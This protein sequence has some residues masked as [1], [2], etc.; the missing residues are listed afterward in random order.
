VSLLVVA[1][2]TEPAM[3]VAFLIGGGLGFG[4]F[5]SNH[6]AATQTLAGPLASGRWTG[7]ENFTG[8]L[9]GPVAPV[10]VG[11]VVDRTGQY[12]AAFAVAAAITLVG[13][14]AWTFVIRDVREVR[15]RS[16]PESPVLAAH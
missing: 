8:N 13:A 2:T 14:A 6:W 15:W 7:M 1:W 9:A 16:T 3:T 12:F 10:V 4:V 5:S 11:M